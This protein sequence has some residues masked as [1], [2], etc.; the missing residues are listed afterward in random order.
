MTYTEEVFSSSLDQKIEYLDWYSLWIILKHPVICPQSTVNYVTPFCI[1]ILSSAV[2][3]Y[4]STS[5]VL[6]YW[7]CRH[8]Y[9]EKI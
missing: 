1:H 8:I 7:G 3:L 9:D 2:S 5:Y 4:R 6:T